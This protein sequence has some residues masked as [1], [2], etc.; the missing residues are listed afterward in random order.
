MTMMKNQIE[1][2]RRLLGAVDWRALEGANFAPMTLINPL[3]QLLS[4]PSSLVDSDLTA[5]QLSS[6]AT[7]DQLSLLEVV[8]M[9][10]K[11]SSQMLSLAEL[12]L[13]IFGV[14]GS[15]G[16]VHFE[17]VSALHQAQWTAAVMTHRKVLDMEGKLIVTFVKQAL[18][19]VV[20]VEPVLDQV[21]NF[22]AGREQYLTERLQKGIRLLEAQLPVKTTA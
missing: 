14:S 5:W 6:V 3:D 19:A 15:Y 16:G 20:L 22:A 9:L 1:M 18:L 7:E 13:P 17:L 11:I 2:A 21:D 8:G 12:P 10:R 4:M